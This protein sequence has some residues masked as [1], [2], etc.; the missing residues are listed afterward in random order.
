M[1]EF[2]PDNEKIEFRTIVLTHIRNVL[3]LSLK[4][5]SEGALKIKAMHDAVMSLSDVLLPFYDDEMNKCYTDYK[6]NIKDLREKGI[7]VHGNSIGGIYYAG[8]KNITRELFRAL[9]LLM[10]RIDY[11]KSSIYGD[12]DSSDDVVEDEGEED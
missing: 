4:T 1:A 8:L 2:T 5:T 12:N 11:L 6:K 9:N 10:K 3:N 7:N